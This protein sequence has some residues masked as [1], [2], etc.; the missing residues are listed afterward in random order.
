MEAL[1]QHGGSDPDEVFFEAMADVLGHPWTC[2]AARRIL[3]PP[4]T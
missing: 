2:P 3:T 1:A 4:P